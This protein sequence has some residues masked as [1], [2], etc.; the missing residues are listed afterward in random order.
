[1]SRYAAER[2]NINWGQNDHLK[3]LKMLA[4]VVYDRER[5]HGATALEARVRVLYE[6]VVQVILGDSGVTLDAVRSRTL[7]EQGVDITAAKLLQRADKTHRYL[8]ENEFAIRVR[9]VYEQLRSNGG[10]DTSI[11]QQRGTR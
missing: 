9:Q 11:E 1:M 8:E 4:W 2:T 3:I 10:P 5:V 6:H 7:A